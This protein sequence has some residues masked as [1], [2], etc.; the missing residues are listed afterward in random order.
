MRRFSP[1]DRLLIQ[2]DQAV[3]TVWGRPVTTGRPDP[4]AGCNERKLSEHERRVAGRLM[5]VNHV[6]EICAQALYQGQSLTARNE[7]T[8]HALE[9][10][11]AEENDHLAWCEQRLQ[12][13]GSRKSFLNPL[14]YAGSFSIGALA[15]FAGDRWNLGF[16]AETERQVVAHLDRHLDRLPE[17]DTRTRAILEQ[18]KIDEGRHATSALRA[19][20]ALLPGP[21]SRAMRFA[22]RLMTGTAYWL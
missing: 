15:G 9:R 10:A 2:A 5:R 8:Q 4:A 22:S 20:G 6:G 14:W 13:L 21:V 19:G 16:L 1:L 18:M 11:A 12:E 7:K 3:R 17:Q